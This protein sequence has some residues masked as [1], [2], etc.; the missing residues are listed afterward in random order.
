MIYGYEIATIL[1]VLS[2]A[3][4]W[5]S[6][7]IVWKAAYAITLVVALSLGSLDV[8]AITSITIF[9]LL[10]AGYLRDDKYWW[11]YFAGL[12]LIGV[13]FGL[14]IVPGYNN[15]EYLTSQR[16]SDA[17]GNLSIWFNYDK[18]LFGL[19]VLG[20]VFHKEL[21]RS[22]GE[23]R[24]FIKRLLP[25]VFVAIPM[26]YLIGIGMGYVEYD[27]TPSAIF[28]PWALKNLFFTV[29]AEEI[30]FRG[31]IQRELLKRL[32]GKYSAVI[33]VVGA[34]VLFGAAHFAGGIEYVILSSIAGCVYGY[35]Y[36]ATGRIE[37]AFATHFL[38][39]AGHFIFLSYPFLAT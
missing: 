8:S 22:W 10:L 3:L 30:M 1:T 11:L 32:S 38:L 31:L 26:V 25:I 17:V 27:F 12:L 18:S 29:I 34:G 5:V 16:L 13:A 14:H 35:A 21:I 36:Y 24:V 9:L 20:V 6:K 2:A 15:H 39:N 23:L 19:V 7:E 28:W 37:A 4:I 33:S